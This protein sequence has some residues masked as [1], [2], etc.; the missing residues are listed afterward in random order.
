MTEWQPIET[1][2]KDGETWVLVFAPVDAYY[3]SE[4]WPARIAEPRYQ[5][6]DGK[7]LA[8]GIGHDGTQYGWHPT[9]WMPLPK[10]P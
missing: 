10:P 1:A 7:V 4:V 8:I 6:E 5:G 3:R 2:P 9:H